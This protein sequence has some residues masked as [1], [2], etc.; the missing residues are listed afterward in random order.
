MLIHKGFHPSNQPT[1]SLHIYT[2]LEV[3]VKLDFI[4][5]N[6]FFLGG[7]SAPD[8]DISDGLLEVFCLTSSF[9]IAQLQVGL[10]EP[11]RLGQCSSL[12]IQLKGAAPMQVDGEPWN[13]HPGVI[14]ITHSHKAAILI[15]E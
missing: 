9:H 5:V 13:Q 4:K 14:S 1:H 3:E 6:F 2:L 8:Q 12:N 10:S 7:S 15:K 11:V